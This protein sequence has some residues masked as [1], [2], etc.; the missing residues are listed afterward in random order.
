MAQGLKSISTE[1]RCAFSSPIFCPQRPPKV[2]SVAGRE[3]CEKME[4]E[5]S[6]D[7]WLYHLLTKTHFGFGQSQKI[8]FSIDLDFTDF[9]SL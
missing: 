5:I 1:L 8:R 7:V 2:C 9:R 3:N 6:F 4:K